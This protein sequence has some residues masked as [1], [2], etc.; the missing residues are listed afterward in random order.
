M[1]STLSVVP[2][3]S[4]ATLNSESSPQGRSVGKKRHGRAE[5]GRMAGGEV[6]G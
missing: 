3:Q 6:M 2:P 4:Y 5:G 1:W